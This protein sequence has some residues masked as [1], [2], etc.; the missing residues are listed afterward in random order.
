MR[1]A[2]VVELRNRL[3]MRISVMD[4]GATLLSC[5]LPLRSGGSREVVLGC[6]DLAA[7]RAQNVYA[8]AIVGRFTNRIHNASYTYQGEQVLL[9]ANCAGHQLHGGPVGFDRR[10]WAITQQS[11]SQVT[12]SLVSPDGDQG[13][14][15]EL[16]ASVTYALGDALTLRVR[17]EARVNRP[18]PVGL[19]QHAYFNLN[20]D[21][22]SETSSCLDHHLR[23][24]G[25]YWLSA[26]D[27]LSMRE[28][29][30]VEGTGLDF[31]SRRLLSDAIK[32]DPALSRIGGI[33]HSLSLDPAARSSG[34][35]CVLLESADERV[36][37]TLCTDQPAVQLFTGMNLGKLTSRDG[38]PYR[39]NTGIAIEPQFIPNSPN[40]SVCEPYS[41]NCFLTP[42]RTWTST[43]VYRFYCDE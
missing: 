8:G 32:G 35:P 4:E 19:T 17:M 37:M 34:S 11:D 23:V 16:S 20:G 3:G 9:H 29:R 12:F 40:R 43:N 13:F 22:G 26:D 1:G 2:N 27:A 21:F 39:N 14:P 10:I 15:G 42:E 30:H 25:A 28:L 24:D 38:L 5:Q 6:A 41:P 36:R 31:R 7:Y 33:D 18:C